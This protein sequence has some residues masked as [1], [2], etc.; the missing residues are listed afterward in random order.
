MQDIKE[1][2]N[3]AKHIVVFTG[4]GISTSCGIPDFRGPNGLFSYAEEVYGLPYP[5]AIFDINYFKQRQEP[6]FELS[7]ELLSAKIEPSVTHN[8]ISKL[9]DQG[10]LEL[11]IT[12]NIDGL[13][14]RAGNRRILECHGG[15]D[16]AHCFSCNRSYLLREIRDDIGSGIIPRCSCGGV[17]KPD[18]VFYGEN[19]PE[20]FYELYTNPPQMD[21]LLVMG[22]S[23]LVEPVSS[24]ILQLASRTTSILFNR[25]K[26]GF[27]N[28]FTHNHL[29]DLDEYFKELI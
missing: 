2:I 22:T 9:E 19:L 12:Q 28:Y 17:I 4:A 5:E 1:L 23:L 6:F 29:C 26:T 13:H 21:L 14:Q 7:R 16:T 15:Y 18:V 25:D 11:L 10:R 8:F 24:F 3:S 27:E 20:R